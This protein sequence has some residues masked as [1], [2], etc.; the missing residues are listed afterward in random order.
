MTALV[1]YYITYIPYHLVDTV[2]NT[3]SHISFA[4]HYASF[5]AFLSE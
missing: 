1:N 3:N 5:R 2:M 4:Y